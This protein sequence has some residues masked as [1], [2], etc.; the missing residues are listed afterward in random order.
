MNLYEL[1]GAYHH[2]QT[3]IEDGQDGLE[4][5]LESLND[6]IEDKA[7]GYAKVIKNLESQ[8]KAIK[9]EEKRLADRRK[10]LE[11]NVN[12]LKENLEQAMVFNG[13]K[14]I[15]TNLFSFNVQKNPPS[16]KVID[17]DL[18]PKQY[19]EEQA[20][21]LNRRELLNNLKEGELIDGVEITQGESLRIR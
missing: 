11:N 20:P 1:S 5:T 9:E 7:V 16:L 19:Y 12:G 6:A 4:D 14:K 3:M 8:A 2:I 18:I 21:K 15:K 10:S 13:K 17:E